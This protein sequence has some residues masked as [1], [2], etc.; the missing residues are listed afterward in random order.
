MSAAA[1]RASKAVVEALAWSV[2]SLAVSS[3]A[4][5]PCG[6]SDPLG[7][8]AAAIHE[9]VLDN[10]SRNI[11]I[12]GIAAGQLQVI[13]PYIIRQLAA[14]DGVEFSDIV[15]GSPETRHC[16]FFA[17]GRQNAGCA[18]REEQRQAQ[19]KPVQSVSEGGLQQSTLPAA[20]ELDSTMVDVT[21]YGTEL[22]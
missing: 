11:Q 1:C 17:R 21:T 2:P 16:R 8:F 10:G 19:A 15:H 5:T 20:T 18:R 4:E 22:Y 7:P 12:V 6:A 3:S 13:G 14:L 9:A